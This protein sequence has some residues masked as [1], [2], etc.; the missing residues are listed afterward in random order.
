MEHLQRLDDPKAPTT[1][2]KFTKDNEIMELVYM[3]KI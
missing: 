1:K 2:E 3:N